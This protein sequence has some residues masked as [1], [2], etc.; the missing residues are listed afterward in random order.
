MLLLALAVIGFFFI[1]FNI[2]TG[3]NAISQNMDDIV[4]IVESSGFASQ[5]IGLAATGDA[6]AMLIVSGITIL[7]FGILYAIMTASFINMITSNKGSKK[8]AYKKKASKQKSLSGALLKKEFLLLWGTSTYMFNC[9]LGVPIMLIGIVVA[10]WQASFLNQ[11]TPLFEAVPE[12]GNA[13]PVCIV[14]IICFVVSLN[15]ISTPSVSV[16]GRKNI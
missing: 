10:I 2:N 7:A 3:I 11:F 8:V 14:A 9:A 12:F 16:E 6:I 15:V 5:V 13:L 4:Q 1:R